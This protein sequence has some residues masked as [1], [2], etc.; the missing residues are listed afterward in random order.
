ML[1]ALHSARVF[2]YRSPVD[3]RKSYDTL[4]ALVRDDLHCEVLSG[5]IFLFVGRCRRR[6][7]ALHFD[8]T[9]LCLLS[10]RLVKGHFAAPWRCSGT[11]PL[12]LTPNE[13]ALFLEGSE[14]V[15]RLPLSPAPY[16][17]QSEMPARKWA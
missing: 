13:L 2:A 12:L 5:D 4:S 9:G 15:F 17:P 14:L 1:G 7:K 16:C 11:A 6:A 3:M 8:G 10:K